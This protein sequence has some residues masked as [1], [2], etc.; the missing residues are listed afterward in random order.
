[1][2]DQV[3]FLATEKQIDS[4]LRNELKDKIG[5]QYVLVNHTTMSPPNATKTMNV[6]NKEIV[7]LIDNQPF[8]KTEIHEIK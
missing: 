5:K 6:N 8:D 3:I 7:I 2:A 4:N 1:M